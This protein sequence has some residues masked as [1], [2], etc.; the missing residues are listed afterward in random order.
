MNIA[1]RAMINAYANSFNIFGGRLEIDE[2]KNLDVNIRL[3]YYDKYNFIKKIIFFINMSWLVS[4]FVLNYL[5]F[6]KV[7]FIS[8]LLFV[9]N[10]LSVHIVYFVLDK[11]K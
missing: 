9:L 4:I 10:I 5:N 7:L 11:H 6:E 2:I 3:E 8:T 1:R